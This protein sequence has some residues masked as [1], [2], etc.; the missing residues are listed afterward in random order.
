MIFSIFFYL[1]RIKILMFVQSCA[2]RCF[3]RRTQPQHY[4]TTFRL[5]L[6]LALFCVP[7]VLNKLM[8]SDREPNT[9]VEVRPPVTQNDVT[10]TEMEHGVNN[11][12]PVV[13]K[14]VKLITRQTV[15]FVK[16]DENVP[17]RAKVL[18]RAEKATGTCKHWYNLQLLETDGCY[19]QKEAVDL[20]RVSNLSIEPEVINADV[21]ITKDTSFDVAK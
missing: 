16:E 13:P 3:C 18:G 9:T 15:T 14:S 19:G 21:L 6:S 12:I 11:D 17:C 5:T 20:S 1:L 7:S 8:T 4:I 2:D 10:Q